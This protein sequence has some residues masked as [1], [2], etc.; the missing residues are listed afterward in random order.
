MGSTETGE[1]FTEAQ[2]REMTP[3]RVK[4]LGL[5]KL[6]PGDVEFLARMNR[7]DRRAWLRA[8]KRKEVREAKRN[9]ANLRT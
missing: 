4:D 3:Q 1:M 7:R 9:D 8:N 5:V 2:V 6:T